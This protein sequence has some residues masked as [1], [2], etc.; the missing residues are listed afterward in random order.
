MGGASPKKKAETNDER[1]ARLLAAKKSS[2]DALALLQ[3]SEFLKRARR[4][5][6]LFGGPETGSVS[7]GLGPGIAGLGG[8]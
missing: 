3:Q 4:R 8:S 7:P 5:S 6:S 2:L 1:N